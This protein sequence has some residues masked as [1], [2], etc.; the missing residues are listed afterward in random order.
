MMKKLTDLDANQLDQYAF[1]EKHQ[2]YRMVIVNEGAIPEIKL[3]EQ[4]SIIGGAAML[5]QEIRI[6]RIEVPQ[7]VKETEIQQVEKQVIVK[8]L[9]IKE[10]EKQVIVKEVQIE[11]V[12]I[13]VI[14]VEYKTVEV[15]VIQK[16]VQ[17]VQVEKHNK[18]LYIAQAITLLIILISKFVH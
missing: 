15:P 3:S 9:E 7:I 17:I 14:Q 18:A 5:N 11:R 1:D 16:E 6:E 10:I 4:S 13:P 8:E 12:E 2:A